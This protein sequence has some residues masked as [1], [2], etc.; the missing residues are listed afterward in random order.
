MRLVVSMAAYANK[1]SQDACKASFHHTRHPTTGVVAD[2]PQLEAYP[3]AYLFS[4]HI[5]THMNN[6]VRRSSQIYLG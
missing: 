5:E 6:Q 1:P 3:K 4:I 2:E